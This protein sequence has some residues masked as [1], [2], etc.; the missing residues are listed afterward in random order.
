MKLAYASVVKIRGGGIVKIPRQNTKPILKRFK[1]FFWVQIY[2]SIGRGAKMRQRAKKGQNKG[3]LFVP[4]FCVRVRVYTCVIT[5]V[6]V[7]VGG[8]ILF[9]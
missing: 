2:K 9:A 8:C 5:C 4:R 6:R 7:Y 1:R 3:I